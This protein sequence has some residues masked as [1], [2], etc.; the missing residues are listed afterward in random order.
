MEKEITTGKDGKPSLLGM[1]WSP[2][3]QLEKIRENPRIWGALGIIV[4]LYIIGSTI[5][6]SNITAEDL[7]VSGTISLADAEQILG[8]T[9]TITVVSVFIVALVGILI[10]SS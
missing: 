3:E 8:F 1:F 6:A 7:V 10:S 4:L 5:L 2:G 9:K